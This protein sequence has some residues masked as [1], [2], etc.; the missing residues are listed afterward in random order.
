MSQ[1]KASAGWGWIKGG[2][3]MLRKQPGEL[4]TMLMG[5]MCALLVFSLIPLIGPLL[6]AILMPMLSVAFMRAGAHIELGKRA[7]PSLLLSGF[8]QPVVKPL[9]ALGFVNL[10]VMG[11][12]IAIFLMVN[13]GTYVKVVTGELARDADEVRDSNFGMSLLSALLFY[14]PFGM[15]L[16]FAPALV[17]WQKM[18]VGKAI[19]Y[20]FFAVVRSLKAFLVFVLC[21]FAILIVPAQLV[22]LL[23]GRSSFAVILMVPLSLILTVVLQ[24]SFYASYREIFGLPE[25]EADAEKPPLPPAE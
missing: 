10:V 16:L 24:C 6:P 21:W 5:Y 9:V 20:S 2:F 18:S 11:L 19:F 7:M 22:A 23:F 15:A 25:N 13:D 8:R 4:S 1:R 14:V 3:G 17:Y 12:A